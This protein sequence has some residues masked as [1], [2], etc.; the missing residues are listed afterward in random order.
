MKRINKIAAKA[1]GTQS[2]IPIAPSP[3]VSSGVMHALRGSSVVHGQRPRV[4]M[5]LS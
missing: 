2:A 1:A 5:P 3:S 4:S